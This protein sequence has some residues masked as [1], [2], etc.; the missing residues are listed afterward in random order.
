M[1][2]DR[3]LLVVVAILIGVIFGLL[4]AMIMRANGSKP[5]MAVLGAGGG[6]VSAV[7]VTLGVMAALGLLGG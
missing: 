3:V 6:F 4:T 1:T 7:T 5:A 2:K